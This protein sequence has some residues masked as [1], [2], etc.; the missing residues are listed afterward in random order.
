MLNF[1]WQKP[2]NAFLWAGGRAVGATQTFLGI[3]PAGRELTFDEDNELQ[4]IYRG[5]LDLDRIRLKIGDLG[6]FKFGGAAFT[7]TNTIYIPHSWLPDQ[8]GENYCSAKYRLL[9]HET[10]HVWQYQ[11]GGLNYMSESLAHQFAGWYKTG[12][13]GAAYDFERGIREGKTWAQLNPEQQARL[14]EAAYS[15]GLFDEENA[16]F[17]W[18]ETDYTDYAREAIRQMRLRQGAP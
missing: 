1:I 10:L 2:F 14:I 13:R 12:T 16:V 4:K 11:N 17:I 15:N 7:L 8:G 3:E 5:A 6:L 9:A 18:N